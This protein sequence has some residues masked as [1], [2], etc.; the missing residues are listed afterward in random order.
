M[1]KRL[2]GFS[3]EQ[4]P[5]PFYDAEN[6]ARLIK[7]GKNKDKGM[8]IKRVIPFNH[9]KTRWSAGSLAMVLRQTSACPCFRSPRDIIF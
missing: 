6:D 7:A 3:A 9:K 4:S 5:S 2:A 8:T 1:L